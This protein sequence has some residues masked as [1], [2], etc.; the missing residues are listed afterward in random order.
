MVN[1]S[2]EIEY[3]K[4]MRKDRQECSNGLEADQRRKSGRAAR[5]ETAQALPGSHNDKTS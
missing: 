1:E 4:N 5:G 3:Y 2:C